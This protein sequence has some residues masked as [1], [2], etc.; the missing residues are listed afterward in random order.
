M[1][2]I[3]EG[4][5]LP[6]AQV[7]TNQIEDLTTTDVGI[8][9]AKDGS[10]VIG[11]DVSPSALYNVGKFLEILDNLLSSLLQ[12]HPKYGNGHTSHIVVFVNF[13]E[14]SNGKCFSLRVVLFINKS[15]AFRS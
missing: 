15:L 9:F 14:I 5:N 11:L 7:V 4:D 3:I 12:M 13:E 1:E 10:L 8:T 6:S 2:L